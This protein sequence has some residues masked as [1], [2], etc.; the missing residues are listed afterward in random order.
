MPNEDGLPDDDV[1]ELPDEEDELPEDGEDALV[2]E[3]VDGAADAKPAPRPT[4]ARP[5]PVRTAV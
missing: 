2:P 3:S 1:D 4:E 5:M